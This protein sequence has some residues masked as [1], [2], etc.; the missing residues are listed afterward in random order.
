M[1][2]TQ[3]QLTQAL[4]QLLKDNADP[5]ESAPPSNMAPDFIRATHVYEHEKA[6]RKPQS[7]RELGSPVAE[8]TNSFTP[9]VEPAPVQQNSAPEF[10][11]AP[12]EA[13]LKEVLRHCL[14][15]ENQTLFTVENV[16]LQQLLRIFQRLEARMDGLEEL[17]T[18]E[19]LGA[20]KDNKPPEDQLIFMPT[21]AEGSWPKDKN[22]GEEENNEEEK[23]HITIEGIDYNQD[24]EEIHQ[25][26]IVRIP[27]TGNRPNNNLPRGGGEPPRTK[28]NA[29]KRRR[30][31]RNR[32]N[33]R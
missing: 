11:L 4:G 9:V 18:D 20:S 15:V 28:S 8:P 22:H 17:I 24:G 30:R 10:V 5:V 19:L 3:E 29:R 6:S 2:I 21:P 13:D 1:K 12:M 7:I 16:L 27:D 32:K 14:D 23:V 25:G 26:T 33:K 31:K